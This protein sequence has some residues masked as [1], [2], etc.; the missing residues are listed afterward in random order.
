MFKY[1]YRWK[2]DFKFRNFVHFCKLCKIAWFLNFYVKENIENFNKVVIIHRL[3][4]KL[5]F[6]LIKTLKFELFRKIHG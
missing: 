3:K 4:F 1:F 2:T 6:E 5:T